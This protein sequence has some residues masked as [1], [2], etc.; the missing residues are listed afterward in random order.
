M[1]HD[2]ARITAVAGR[3][4]DGALSF[5][6]EKHVPRGGPDGGDGGDG[7]DVVLVADSDL[8]DLSAFRSRR[9]YAA[10]RGGPGRGTGKHGADGEDAVLRV[11]VGTQVF[12]AEGHLIADLAHPGARA[13]VGRGGA[14]GRGNRRFASSTLQTPRFAETGLPGEEA[15]LELHLK[16]LADAALVGL[17]NAGKSSLLAR[18]SNAKPKIADYPFTTLEPVLGTLDAPDGSQLVVADVPGLIEGAAEGAGLGHEFLA[19]LERARMLVHVVDAAAGEL[20]AHYATIRAELGSY[21]AGLDELPEVL[22]LN[23]ID[24]LPEPPVF[25]PPGVLAV[26]PLSCATGEGVEAFRRALFSLVPPLPEEE[27]VEP[28][29]AD[30]LVYRPKPKATGVPHPPHRPRLPRGGPRAGQGRAGGGP[31]SGRRAFWRR[32]R[33]RRRDPGVPVTLVFGGMFDPPHVGHV[34]VVEGAKRHFGAARTLV[35]VVAD[36]GHREVV[37]SAADRLALARAAFPG[38]D[39][40]LDEHPRTIDM[41]RARRL[42]DPVLVIGA[43]ELA[44]FPSWKEPEAVL[45]LARLAVGERP[46]SR[47]DRSARGRHVLRDRADAGQLHGHPPPRR[48]RRADRRPRAA[49]GGRGDRAARS[50]PGL[51]SRAIDSGDRTALTSLEQAR[52]IAGIAQE[53]LARDVVILDMRPVCSYT[54]YFVICSGGNSRQTKAI[55]D[56]VAHSLKDDGRVLPRSVDGVQEGTWIVADYLDV[57]LHVFTPD[58][59]GFYKL[60]ELWSDVPS[61]EVAATA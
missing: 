43:D 8:R 27:P 52:R 9:T 32:G 17:P 13:V 59:R 49:C 51:D 11:A 41:L 16:L 25:E 10:G 44:D 54:D 42:D 6:R 26:F 37:A 31:A 35:L 29:M 23:K 30:Y 28:E 56:E 3:G 38:E 19:H 40:E 39:V 33:G 36:P 4:G 20:D 14:G 57:V 58:T 5:R 50:V 48:R 12:D 21:G 47:R 18:I 53:K 61:I 34:R 1:F 24:L 46:G 45:E 2:R 7:G 60:E 55:Y 15:E 22:V